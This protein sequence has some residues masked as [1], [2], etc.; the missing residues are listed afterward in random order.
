MSDQIG[1][2]FDAPSLIERARMLWELKAARLAVA[3]MGSVVGLVAFFVWRSQPAEVAVAP[4][5][6]VAG[7]SI[8]ALAGSTGGVETPL[9]SGAATAEPSVV[10]VDMIGPV[11]HPG[12]VKLPSGSRVSDAIAAAGGLARGKTVIN[13]ARTL[14]DGEQIDVSAKPNSDQSGQGSTSGTS[15][16]AGPSKA[17]VDIN[18]ASTVELE[19][20]PRIGPVTAQKIIDYRQSN[21]GF[22]S[23][24]Q[25]RE[26]PGIGEV[27]FAGL[28]PLVRV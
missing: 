6:A 20:L 24:D 13:L 9:A 2:E 4:T 15:G 18:N 14:V 19:T 3:V 12:I 1:P 25:L 26:V 23:V 16:A 10:I 5:V 11:R 22:R 28:A 7:S 21:G 8:D 17:K 27:T